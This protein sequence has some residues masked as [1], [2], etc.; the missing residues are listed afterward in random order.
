[1]KVEIKQ[2]QREYD[3]YFKL[4]K[5]IFRHEKFDGTMSETIER[6][7]IDR[8]NAV[9][10]LLYH[11][12]KNTVLLIK[13]FRCA[14]YLH[15]GPGWLI[16]IVAGI[17]DKGRDPLTTARDEVLEEVGYRVQNLIPLCKFYP[18]PG[19]SSETIQV[20]LGYLDEAERINSGGGLASEHEDIQLLELPFEKALQMIE[21]GEI[22]DGKTIIALQSLY[23]RQNLP[24][25]T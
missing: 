25:K 9:A 20:Y 22:C 11:R 6:L 18:T 13:Q 23:I 3:G 14:A 2:I 24:R 16:E 10:V 15:G 1:M 12:E 21:T 4:D 5:V 17:Q 19:S 7:V 8:G